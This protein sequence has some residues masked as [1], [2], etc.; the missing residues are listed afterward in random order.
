MIKEK[1]RTTSVFKHT[2]PEFPVLYMEIGAE[3]TKKG[4]YR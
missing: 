2:D 1:F 4:F 3:T